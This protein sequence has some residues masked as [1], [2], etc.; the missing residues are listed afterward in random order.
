MLWRGVSSF[1]GIVVLLFTALWN[2]LISAMNAGK[3]KEDS[4]HSERAPAIIPT[5]RRLSIGGTD[6]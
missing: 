3:C 1:A 2:V 6:E 4:L 5:G